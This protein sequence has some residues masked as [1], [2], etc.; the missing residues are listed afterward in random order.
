LIDL[1]QGASLICIKGNLG[2]RYL[3]KNDNCF[4]EAK[5]VFLKANIVGP[6]SARNNFDLM[7]NGIRFTT[8]R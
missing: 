6:G 5:H 2:R 7:S 4:S 1:N 3:G 8:D